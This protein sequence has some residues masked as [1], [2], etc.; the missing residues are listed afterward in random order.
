MGPLRNSWWLWGASGLPMPSRR[1]FAPAIVA[2]ALS[3][4]PAL[5]HPWLR[6]PS[7]PAREHGQPLAISSAGKCPASRAAEDLVD[8]FDEAAGEGEDVVHIHPVHGPEAALEALLEDIRIGVVDV[9]PD[10]VAATFFPFSA[11]FSPC[12]TLMAWPPRPDLPTCSLRL[13]GGI[14]L[15]RSPESGCERAS[16]AAWAGGLSPAQRLAVADDLFVTVRDVRRLAGDWQQ[17][18]DR[19]REATL[20]ARIFELAAFRRFD[21]ANR[22]SSPLANPG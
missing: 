8:P 3:E 15:N 19:A 1:T 14:S 20:A 21:E 6:L 10:L 13:G 22:G 5:R 7:T 2:S 18:D 11:F 16:D 12:G 9:D 4:P 17:I